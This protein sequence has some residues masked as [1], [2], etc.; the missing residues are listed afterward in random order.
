[1]FPCDLF[2][3]LILILFYFR[4]I[5]HVFIIGFLRSNTNKP[6]RMQAPS[7][8]RVVSELSPEVIAAFEDAKI[9]ALDVEGV[10]LSSAGER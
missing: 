1:L 7:E 9:V 6:Q 5:S 4:A 3:T 8:T 10:D 2:H